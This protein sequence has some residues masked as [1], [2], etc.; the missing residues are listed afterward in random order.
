MAQNITLWSS[1]FGD[2]AI[3]NLTAQG[4]QFGNGGAIMGEEGN[5][6][7]QVSPAG[8][9]PGGTGVD[10][11]LAVYS[12]PAN[13]FDV[14]GR[15]INIMALGSMTSAATAKTLK[16]IY[17]A[18]TAVVGSAVI[19]GTTIASFSD[20]TAN[21]AG[22]WQIAANVFK[23]G[24]A[25]SNTQIALHEASQSGTVLGALVA[26]SLVTAVESA[27]ILIAITGNAAVVGNI[28][29][30]FLEVNAMN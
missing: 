6:N 30:N 17:N 4:F 7:R 28:T 29:F 14:A 18:T 24:A 16:I 23:Y 26:P 21:S 19:G 8:V 15:G 10:S 2:V 5:V 13:S 1:R 12:L 25:G 22:G 3:P 27:P 11:V 9:N 20:S